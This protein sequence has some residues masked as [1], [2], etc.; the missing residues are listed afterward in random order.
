MSAC[1]TLKSSS[2]FTRY[3]PTLSQML[4]A[5]PLVSTFALIAVTVFVLVDSVKTLKGLKDGGGDDVEINVRIMWIFASINL[6]LDFINIALFLLK[7]DDDGQWRIQ[8][9][10]CGKGGGDDQ[11]D[12]NEDNLN[13]MSALAHVAA[14][15]LRS[16]AVMIAGLYAQL[17]PADDSAKADAVAAIVVSVAIAGSI[18]PLMSSVF[19]KVLELWGGDDYS[20]VG[21]GSPTAQLLDYD[22]V[23]ASSE[24]DEEIVPYKEVNLTLLSPP[25]STYSVVNPLFNNK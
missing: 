23:F 3:V 22:D 15:T 6:V 21:S 13:M 20:R 16:V 10:G 9:C 11:D 4:Q 17:S 25:V 2:P 1:I 24:D 14:D 19:W 8:C 18:F 7:K 5:A 12:S